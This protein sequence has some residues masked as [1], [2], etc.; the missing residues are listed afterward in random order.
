MG[1]ITID[2]TIHAP[3]ATVFAY[4]DDYRNTT[5]YM[6]DLV[7][8][9]PTGKVTHG[10]G[11]RFGVGMKAGPTTLTSVVDI[12]TWSENKAIG[13]HSNEG[14]KQIGMWVF[15]PKGDTT[16]VTFDMEYEFGGGIAGKLLGR[17]AE[18]IVRSN[19]Q[20]SVETSQAQHR[21]A[22]CREAG[23]TGGS[24][25]HHKICNKGDLVVGEKHHKSCNKACCTLRIQGEK[26]V[27][28]RL[29]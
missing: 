10:K 9:Q 7:K 25:G 17:A 6:K 29:E 26:S 15:K 21:E 13:W 12:T 2:M 22:R 19:L 11:A 5:K 24:E 20:R 8:W 16:Q 18:P 27:E 4:V 3:V 28:K 23:R 1:R 14:F